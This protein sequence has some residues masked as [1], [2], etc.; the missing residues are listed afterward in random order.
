MSADWLNIN[1][2]ESHK[3][4]WTLSNKN[5]KQ[6]LLISQDH[7]LLLGQM[8]MEMINS[9]AWNHE[10]MNVS[11]FCFHISGCKSS[12]IIDKKNIMK[13]CV[14]ITKS[15]HCN[16]IS[17]FKNI[18]SK[19][20]DRL[21]GLSHPHFDERTDS[22]FSSNCHDNENIK[23]CHNFLILLAKRFIISFYSFHKSFCSS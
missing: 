4:Y 11:N 6:K 1:Y 16:L 13:K 21:S 23:D 18:S 2:D 22:N 17:L 5:S 9:E 15:F 19:N 20:V 14:D 3:C 8:I 7:Q 12:S 10:I